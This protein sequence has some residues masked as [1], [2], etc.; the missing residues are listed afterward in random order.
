MK[1][2]SFSNKSNKLDSNIEGVVFLH[3]IFDAQ[4]I[5]DGD[6]ALMTFMSGPYLI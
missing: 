5:Y 3:D 4:H 6:S 2:S 1:N